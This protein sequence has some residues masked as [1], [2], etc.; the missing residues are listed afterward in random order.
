MIFFIKGVKKLCL[1]FFI[2]P[3]WLIPFKVMLFYNNVFNNNCNFVLEKKKK[4][5]STLSSLLVQFLSVINIYFFPHEISQA[6][7]PHTC[8]FVIESPCFYNVFV[9][10]QQCCCNYFNERTAR[11]V[12]SYAVDWRRRKLHCVD[13]K[14]RWIH[15]GVCQV[16][17]PPF[18]SMWARACCCCILAWE[19]P[20][21][22]ALITP[23]LCKCGYYR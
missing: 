12:R 19:Q 6:L 11:Y 13:R 15:S 2:C 16:S 4:L 23:F 18:E 20:T 17:R 7:L 21:N 22:W 8:M 5:R 9:I 3:T 14:R 1:F 10:T